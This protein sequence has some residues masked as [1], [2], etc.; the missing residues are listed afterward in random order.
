MRT[1]LIIDDAIFRR[2][3]MLAAEQN[4]S[5]SEVTQ[6]VLR[7]GLSQVRQTPR[8]T[9]VRLPSFSMGRPLVDVADRDQL[10]EVFDRS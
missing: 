2:L 1:T 6:E 7:R 8:R 9:P 10:Y 5:L 3:K 4:R